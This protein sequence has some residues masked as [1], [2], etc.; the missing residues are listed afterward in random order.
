MI[1]QES[2]TLADRP[3]EILKII[4][5]SSCDP[6]TRKEEKWK[7]SPY[8]TTMEVTIPEYK[9][10]RRGRELQPLANG[11]GVTRN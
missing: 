1:T 9:G 10:G 3:L 2:W 6:S 7:M 11:G 5:D 4:E 8:G